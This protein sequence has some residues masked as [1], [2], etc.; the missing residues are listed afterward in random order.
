MEELFKASLIRG[1]VFSA[2]DRMGPMPIY[3]FPKS[4]SEEELKEIKDEETSLLKLSIRDYIQMSIKNLSL[5]LG[6]KASSDYHSI[7]NLQHFAILP[8]PDFKLTSLTFFRF[9]KLKS[10]KEPVPIAFSILV[11][12]N[13]SAGIYYVTFNSNSQKDPLPS[14][15]YFYRL[16]VGDFVATKKMIIMK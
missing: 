7:E 1:L 2:F 15:V 10:R 16:Q 5:L 11:D 12:E 3:V 6:D 13:K 8:Y 9:F 4:Y 14:G